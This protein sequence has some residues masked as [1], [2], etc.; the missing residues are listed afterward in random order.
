MK[1]TLSCML[2]LLNIQLFHRNA[3]T[4]TQSAISRLFF[5]RLDKPHAQCLNRPIENLQDS[6]P[7]LKFWRQPVVRRI[8]SFGNVCLEIVH[9]MKELHGVLALAGKSPELHCASKRSWHQILA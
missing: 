6:A 8:K 9:D 5:A 3:G 1:F 7:I 4:Q 2:N